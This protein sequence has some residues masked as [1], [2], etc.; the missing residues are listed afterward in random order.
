MET[1]ACRPGLGGALIPKQ[2]SAQAGG[3]GPN[4]KCSYNS[5]V[6]LGDRCSFVDQQTLKLQVGARGEGGAR[7]GGTREQGTA[8]GCCCEMVPQR[9]SS[10]ALRA[11]RHSPHPLRAL[12]PPP[13]ARCRSAPRTCRR[14]SCR[15]RC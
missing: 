14:A 5:F 10:G 4:P 12:V 8:G 13:P 7:G 6:V 15:A 11:V 9:R 3:A 2:C 1:V